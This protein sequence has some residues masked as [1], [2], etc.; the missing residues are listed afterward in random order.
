MIYN[1]GFEVR[2]KGVHFLLFNQYYKDP[3]NP[4]QYL[5]NC[6]QTLLGWWQSGDDYGCIQGTKADGKD[7][8]NAQNTEGNIVL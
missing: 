7:I 4:S 1:E 8:I 2:Y 6:A 3:H 5:S